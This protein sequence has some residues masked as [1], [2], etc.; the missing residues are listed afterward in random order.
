MLT[1]FTSTL[2]S[3]FSTWSDLYRLPS[4]CPLAS[5][6]EY[7]LSRLSLN[8]K[9]DK[10]KMLTPERSWD[11]GVGLRDEEQSHYSD[12]SGQRCFLD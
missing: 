1:I 9:I 4:V 3:L 11:E 10:D 5:V 6:A 2:L 7:L 8:C 12:V